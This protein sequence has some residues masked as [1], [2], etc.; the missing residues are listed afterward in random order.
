MEMFEVE[1]RNSALEAEVERLNA[2]IWESLYCGEPGPETC[3]VPTCRGRWLCSRMT[4]GWTP[5]ALNE[6]AS[7]D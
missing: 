6:E 2:A 4:K 7:D 3:S 1:E 5:N